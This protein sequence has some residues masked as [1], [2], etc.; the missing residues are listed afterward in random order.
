MTSIAKIRIG[1]III[2]MLGLLVGWFVVSTEQNPESRFGLHY[3]LDLSGGAHLVY[4]AD[5][6][7]LNPRD[8][9]EAMSALRGVIERRVN[10]FGVSEPNVQIE[11]GGLGSGGEHRLIVE[12]PGVTDV[13]KAIEDIG[14]TPLL[15]F[16]L[17]G[18]QAL[19]N[20][21]ETSTTSTADLL[22]DS[23]LTGRL[24]QGAQLQFGQGGV[25]G[26]SNEP[27]IAVQF[28][29]EGADLFEKITR[30]NTGQILYILLDGEIISDP[31][32]NEPIAGGEA[33]ITGSFTPEEARTLVRDLNLGALPVP[34]ELVSTQTIGPTLGAQAR[35]AGV[36][37]GIIGL[38]FV[39]LYLIFWYRLPGVIASVALGFYLLMLLALFKL[40]PVVLTAAG[41]AGFI[42]SIGMAVDA[43]VLIFERM[44]EELR[45]I[46][47]RHGGDME[48]A[49]REGFSRAWPSIRDG[50]TSSILTA[51]VLYWAGTTLTKGFAITWGLGILISMF[52]AIIITRSFLLALGSDRLKGVHK[53]LYATGL[54]NIDTD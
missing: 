6:S 40:I 36:M 4:R 20:I 50:N 8:I 24:L 49:I 44:K 12:L 11:Q 52:S 21:D 27:V 35:D 25:G 23:G 37:A 1:A 45:A 2:F 3:G 30:E 47:E 19:G 48:K 22:V 10:A 7:D 34:I 43:N 42:L 15:E 9:D 5:V 14:K 38:A 39:G 53:F 18:G 26:F 28:N 13:E 17:L 41:I 51:I 46:N 32:I 33:V 29:S 31:R 16:K 54:S